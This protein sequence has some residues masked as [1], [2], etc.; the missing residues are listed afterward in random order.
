M[1]TFESPKRIIPE[2]LSSEEERIWKEIIDLE[3]AYVS[4]SYMNKIPAETRFAMQE[5][6]VNFGEKLKEEGID[7]RRYLLWH[8]LIGSSVPE[9]KGFEFDL[10]DHRIEKFIRKLYMEYKQ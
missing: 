7:P 8:K 2:G 1:E 5:N 9:R 3:L 10:E 4:D 6:I